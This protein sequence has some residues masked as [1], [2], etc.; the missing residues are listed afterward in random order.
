MF[1]VTINSIWQKW[2]R[3]KF[4]YAT[5]WNRVVIEKLTVTQFIKKFYTFYTRKKCIAV[6]TSP[7]EAGGPPL[8]GCPRLII[9]ATLSI[10]ERSLLNPEDA[11]C[12]VT[13]DKAD[14]FFPHWLNTLEGNC[15]TDIVIPLQFLNYFHL[16]TDT[17]DTFLCNSGRPTFFGERFACL[18]IHNA[19]RREKR[20]DA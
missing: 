20:A 9:Q 15:L 12:H 3:H 5:A 6:F 18:S 11:P 17:V 19:S 14:I 16:W 4:S 7:H 1:K 2:H 8:V 13:S 10:S